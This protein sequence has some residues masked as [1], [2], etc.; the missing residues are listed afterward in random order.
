MERPVCNAATAES[1]PIEARGSCDVFGLML[2]ARVLSGSTRPGKRRMRGEGR[3]DAP[4]NGW[5]E[6][7]TPSTTGA[8]VESSR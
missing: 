2:M 8:G 1:Q 6:P 5:A 3:L 4:R 7:G